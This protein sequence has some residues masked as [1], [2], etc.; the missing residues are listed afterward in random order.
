MKKVKTIIAVCLIVL[1]GTITTG[2]DLG[3]INPKLKTPT[4]V[5]VAIYQKI[6]DE[7]E[8]WQIIKH[9]HTEINTYISTQDN[10]LNVSSTLPSLFYI[11]KKQDDADISN[12][13]NYLTNTTLK[14]IQL[15]DETLCFE[16]ERI[17]EDTQIYIYSIYRLSDRS[18]YLD[19]EKEIENATDNSI[20]ILINN[21][22][23][24]FDK[25]KLIIK[26]NL[27]STEEY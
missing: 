26:T 24:K 18:Y 13:E 6:S 22:K 21:K 15:E 4:F 1:F 11:Y 14:E 20:E 19:Y 3:A 23:D 8:K 12:K 9:D 25:I 16:F 27:S 17:N 7:D 2:C 10:E 5:G